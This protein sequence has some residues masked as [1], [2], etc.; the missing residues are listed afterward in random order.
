MTETSE[1]AGRIRANTELRVAPLVPEL[2]LHLVT[3]R[4]A[5]W[6]ANEAGALAAGLPEPYWA[7]CW[8]GGQALARHVLDHPELVRRRRVVD[9]GSG[10][11]VEGLAALRV[12]ASRVVAADLDPIAA[13]AARLNAE[14]NGLPAPDTETRDL[15]GATLDCDVVLAGDVF[16]DRDLAARGLAWLRQV[17]ATGVLVL[18]G[19]PSRGFLD[20][21]GLEH[22]ATYATCA[23]GELEGPRSRETSV[24]RIPC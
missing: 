9:F 23:D 20:T 15:V 3:D 1:L 24:F 8:P 4:C 14:E 22:V 5:L 7:F 21:G 16:Y 6:H 10:S 13:V 17:A 19:D 2:R 18:V 12:G 11:A